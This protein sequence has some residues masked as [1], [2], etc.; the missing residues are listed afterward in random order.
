MTASQT[1]ITML[2]E[3]EKLS[4][5]SSSN[6]IEMDD[7]ISAKSEFFPNTHQISSLEY[8]APDA[9]ATDTSTFVYVIYFCNQFFACIALGMFQGSIPLILINAGAGLADLGLLTISNYPFS[10]QFLAGPILDRYFSPRLGKRMSYIKPCL[11]TFLILSI[12]TCFSADKY[13]MSLNTLHLAIMSLLMVLNAVILI[14][15]SD[16]Y[17]VSMVPAEKRTYLSMLKQVASA[18]G[19]FVSYNIFVPLNNLDFSNRHLYKEPHTTPWL[20]FRTYFLII[21]A[22]AFIYILFV[23][24][25]ARKEPHALDQLNSMPKILKLTK[26]FWT[27]KYLF[28]CLL[29]ILVWR[30]GFAPLE[31]LFFPVMIQGGFPAVT[32]ID[33]VTL[34]YPFGIVLSVLGGYYALKN[35]QN[36][37]RLLYVHIGIRWLTSFLQ[38]WMLKT[39]SSEDWKGAFWMV[40]LWQVLTMTH[41]SL[42]GIATESFFAEACDSRI[43]TTYMTIYASISSLGDNVPKTVMYFIIGPENWEGITFVLWIYVGI[44]LL[45]SMPVA[46]KIS[47]VRLE[48]LQLEPPTEAQSLIENLKQ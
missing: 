47:Q 29:F 26:G 30:I 32:F 4:K 45:F 27:N 15:S 2:S 38:Y 7:Q 48:E 41:Y 21:S 14:I 17:L 23:Q 33:I 11:Y 28:S 31:A 40:T 8:Y 6:E 9:A 5:L 35:R 24:K 19:G 37:F 25:Y 22:V 13:V 34:L 20:T 10:L 1:A 43:G 12:I 18:T 46:K 16:G 44:L 3:R 36:R 39:Y 42:L